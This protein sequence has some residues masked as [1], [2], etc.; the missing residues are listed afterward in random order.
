M[1]KNPTPA[2]ESGADAALIQRLAEWAMTGL[3]DELEG[4]FIPQGAS[5]SATVREVFAAPEIVARQPEA[6]G[7]RLTVR[8]R[9]SV[10]FEA[11]A[12]FGQI[13]ADDE[14]RDFF[15]ETGDD[16]GPDDCISTSFRM[17][18]ALDVPIRHRPSAP[19]PEDLAL[20]GS[21]EILAEPG[22]DVS[23]A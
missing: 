7:S 8:F 3:S 19:T 18:I 2:A 10:D 9:V 1:D 20:D 17:R 21:P 5:G 23:P 15:G 12:T 22:T 16:G 14:M 11:A 4:I 6:N 13:A